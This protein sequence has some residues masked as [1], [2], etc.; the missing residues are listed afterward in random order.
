MGK[1]ENLLKDV[2]IDKERVKKSVDM[3]LHLLDMGPGDIQLSRKN[4]NPSESYIAAVEECNLEEAKRIMKEKYQDA[5]PAPITL[6][7]Y[8]GKHVLFMGSNR[9]IIFV[10]KGQI[11]DCIIVKIPENRKEP[12]MVS[13]A[14][15]TLKEIIEKER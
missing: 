13:E 2:K 6:L 8:K 14:K 4:I 3:L 5:L 9:G 15:R 1:I 12:E 7:E 11:P 10:L